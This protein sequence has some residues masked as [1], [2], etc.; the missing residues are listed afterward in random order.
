MSSTRPTALLI[1]PI[2][3]EPGGSGRA[4]RAWDWLCTLAKEYDVQVLVTA[5]FDADAVPAGYPAAA[6][7]PLHGQVRS[8]P[9]WGR[10][11]GLLCPALGLVSPSF[12]LDW[13]HPVQSPGAAPA[14]AEALAGRAVE[15]IVVFRLALHPVALSALRSWPEAVAELDLD[16]LESATRLSVAGALWRMGRRAEA[17]RTALMGLQYR[18]VERW[19]RGP[20][21]TLWLAA[22]D[23]ARA[24]R[25]R[26]ASRVT[27]RPN[28]FPAL[29]RLVPRVAGEQVRL[30]FV[31]SLDYP[32]NEESVRFLLGLASK[33]DAAELPWRLT[34]VGRR[35]PE[36]LRRLVSRCSGVE[37]LD[38]S[39]DLAECY[40]QADLVL[41]PVFAGG[42][43]K[44]KT[45]EA[46]AYG[47]PVISTGQGVRGLGLEAGRHYLA[48]ETATEFCEE[49]V[50]LARDQ[51]LRERLV[52]AGRERFEQ[53]FA[54][55]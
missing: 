49:V 41:V 6:V 20:Y 53:G 31:G 8:S 47:R 1:T 18:V 26:L 44:L 38:G 33:L 10:A 45:L 22:P 24:L 34:I 48:A 9:R 46:L 12:M 35:P 40:A 27:W 54:S 2:L 55:Q 5:G 37:L 43:T 29:P 30:L 25:T 32:P 13:L 23:D 14:L 51:V 42:G 11:A 7:W 39:D 50:R 19:L 3:P 15:R 36:L 21:A 17:L 16:D 28:R 4:L 52:A